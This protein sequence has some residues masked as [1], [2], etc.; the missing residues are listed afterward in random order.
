MSGTPAAAYPAIGDYAVIGDLHTA[1]LVGRNGSVD[2][3]C[4]PRFDSPSVFGALLDAAHGGRW[5]IAPRGSWT[6]EQRYLL[7]TNV[8]VTTFHTESGGIVA[9][10]DFMPVAGA[11]HRSS[12]IH[13]RVSCPRGAVEM[14]VVFAPRF[15][16]GALKVELMVRRHGVLATDVEDD[17]ATLAA[18]P[19]ITWQVEEGCAVAHLAL[20]AGEAAWFVLR[21]DD[22]EVHPVEDYCSDEKLDATARWWDEWLARLDY[23]GPYRQEV[24]RSAL[25]LKLCSYEPSGA[26]IAAPTTSL[27]ET[28]GGERN[29]DYRYVWLRDAAFVLYGLERLGL[30]SEVDGF[31][32]FLKRV[33]RRSD[34]RHLQI[35]YGVD[36]RRDLP[37]ETIPRL[38]GYRGARPVRVGNAAAG[39][40]QLDVYGE[41]LETVALWYRRGPVTEGLWKVLRQL[42]DWTATHWR[43]PDFSIWEARGEPKHYVFSKVMAW[44]ALDRGARIATRLQLPAVADAWRREARAVHAAVLER[45]WDPGRRAFVQAFGEP[46]L[47]AAV[48]IIPNIGFLRRSDP[49]VRSTL[50]A[51]RRELASPCEDLIYRYRAPDGLTGGEGTFVA[52]SFW[53]VQNLAMVGEFAEAERLFRHLLRRANHVGLLA[54]E[55]DPASGEQLGNFP[56][57]LSHA[58]LLGTAYLL[59]RLRPGGASPASGAT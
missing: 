36:G 7:A 11:R 45:G 10:T 34:G 2:W 5:S 3:W 53:V 14:E 21:H 58:A 20:R 23:R 12:E 1:A 31:L 39:Q 18:P 41:L 16:Y 57:A 54:E 4:A 47:D 50:E 33:S 52:C 46:Q 32:R 9:V 49:R 13:R 15:D 26:I 44:A 22:D 43:E 24:E 17:V 56:Q 51:V 29:W 55:I 27:P 6:S 8:L 48:L 59:E 19:D 37:E 38:D 30:L 25:V 28:P 35:M 42:V 40:F